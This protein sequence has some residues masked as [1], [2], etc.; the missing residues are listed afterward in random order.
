M[1]RNDARLESW[2]ASPGSNL[3][4]LDEVRGRLDDDL[5]TP[6]AVATIDAAARRGDGVH[7]AAMLL[8]VQIP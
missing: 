5:D 4:L 2:A 6:G 3:G 8:G 1:P 7:E